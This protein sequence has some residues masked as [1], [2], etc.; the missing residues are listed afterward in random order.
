MSVTLTEIA[1]I[2]GVSV[3]TVSRALTGSDH[4]LNEETKQRIIQLAQEMGYHPNL[5]AR[6]LRAKR[7]SMVGIVV[8]NISSNFAPLIVRGIQ[9][10]LLETGFTCIVINSDFESAV[11]VDA[12]NALISF[13]V[14]GIIFVDTWLHSADDAILLSD[15]PY[16]FVNRIFCASGRNCVEV[17]DRYGACLAVQHLVDLGHRRI[18][19][20]NGPDNW[21]ASIR[22]LAG[23]RDVLAANGIPFDLS[24]VK[25]GNWLIQSGYAAAQEL[26]QLHGCPTAIFAGN[27]SMALGAIY[28]LQ[29]AGLNVP[30][31]IAV[32]GYDNAN[33]AH[34]FRPGITTVTMPCYEMGQEAAKLFMSLVKQPKSDTS[35]EKSKRVRGELVIRESCGSKP[36]EK[37]PIVPI[38]SSPRLHKL[39]NQAPGDILGIPEVED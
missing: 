36:L 39:L 33:I 31:D 10:P 12:V 2:A 19:F 35:T 21:N 29:D 18:A 17:D 20:I 11:E 4:P 3:A 38:Q 15:R 6:G 1:N 9:D 30:G 22:R 37:P 26:I 23:Y 32:V 25:N 16:V 5:L 24:L 34:L 8:D 28:A 13:P 27:D 14:A 7:S